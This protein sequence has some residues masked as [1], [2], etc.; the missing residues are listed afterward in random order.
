MRRS[1]GIRGGAN[2]GCIVWL[3]ILG[4]VGYVLMKVIPVKIATSEFY[5]TMQE[6]TS[7]G[8]IKDQKFIEYEILKKAEAAL[9]RLERLRPAWALAHRLG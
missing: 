8:S 6:Q 1:R 2:V 3:V 9:Q 5:D 4:L 7:F